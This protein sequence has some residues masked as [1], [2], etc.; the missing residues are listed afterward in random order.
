MLLNLMVSI[1]VMK[2][3]K[4]PPEHVQKIVDKIRVSSGVSEAIEH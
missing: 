3:T 2:F 1:V 4:T